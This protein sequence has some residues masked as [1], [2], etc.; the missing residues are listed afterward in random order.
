LQDMFSIRRVPSR[1]S[2]TRD[3]QN[4][5]NLKLSLSEKLT[6]A[7]LI[8]FKSDWPIHYKAISQDHYITF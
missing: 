4:D 5:G 2:A 8:Q 7:P 6:L 3:F 1:K